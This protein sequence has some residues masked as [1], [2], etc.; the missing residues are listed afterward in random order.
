M[1]GPLDTE[2]YINKR[3]CPVPGQWL[4]STL[5]FLIQV[6]LATGTWH[7][8]QVGV[9]L[10]LASIFLCV[11]VPGRGAGA[12]AT[13]AGVKGLFQVNLCLRETW[14]QIRFTSFQTKHQHAWINSLRDSMAK[15]KK[16]SSHHTNKQNDQPCFLPDTWFNVI[17]IS[18][19]YKTDDLAGQSSSRM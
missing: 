5:L 3:I 11:M 1:W 7:S 18:N 15:K 16:V 13:A 8:P 4:K 12:K 2:W 14:R 17:Q 6:P 10:K 9:S 19:S